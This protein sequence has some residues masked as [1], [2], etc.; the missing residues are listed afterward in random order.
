[1]QIYN[2]DGAI[3][4]VAVAEGEKQDPPIYV[5]DL[6][7]RLIETPQWLS[8]EKDHRAENIYFKIPRYFG[9]TDLGLANCLVLYEN[10]AGKSGIYP[11]SGY[12]NKSFAKENELLFYWPISGTVS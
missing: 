2:Q 3:R 7:S 10:A 5:V 6:E 8:V 4:K 12:D 11:V 9:A 1:L